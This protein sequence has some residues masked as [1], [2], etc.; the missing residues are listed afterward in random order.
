MFFSDEDRVLYLTLLAKH[1]VKNGVSIWAYCLMDNHVH[2]VAVP[3]SEPALARAVG[4]AHRNYTLQINLREKWSGYLWQGRFSSCPM[5]ERHLYAAVR[6][7]ERN[8]VR[9][10][11]VRYAE[12]YRWSS[13]RAH[14][15]N[16]P[17]TF[18]TG[19]EMAIMAIDDWMAYLRNPDEDLDL[20]TL[21]KGY[22]TGRPLGNEGFVERIESMTGRTLRRQRPG[23]R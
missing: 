11:L 20:K 8:P 6:Y 21:R 16:E 14:A 4:E 9:A 22:R 3:R 1:A 19:E 5:D 17:D 13:A 7:V 12:E 2:I 18:L 15:L 23:P 10:G